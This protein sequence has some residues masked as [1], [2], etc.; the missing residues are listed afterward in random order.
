MNFKNLTKKF[1][2]R[3]TKKE[4]KEQIRYQSQR[5]EPLVLA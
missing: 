5:Q 1:Q 2:K 4:K 3:V